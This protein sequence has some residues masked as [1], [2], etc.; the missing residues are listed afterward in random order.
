MEKDIYVNDLMHRFPG[1]SFTETP[2]GDLVTVAFLNGA[3]AEVA[4]ATTL[5]LVAAYDHIRFN[6]LGSR[7]PIFIST[8]VERDA[9]DVNFL[10]S[11]VLL[12][13][14]DDKVVDFLN[15]AGNWLSTGGVIGVKAYGGMVEDSV[16]G[17]TI[18]NA[19]NYKG[20][21]SASA[22]V[23]NSSGLIAFL[24]NGTA[25][26]LVVGAGGAGDYEVSFDASFTNSGSKNTTGTI[27]VNG[28]P[29]D[30]IMAEVEG[31]S[32]KLRIVTKSGLITL[33]DDDY[34][35]LRFKSE[36]NDDITIYQTEVSLNRIS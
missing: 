35:D 24:N 6:V 33:E 14:T 17:S 25:D 13:N 2:K 26:R 9:L 3:L 31:D 7:N 12:W 16:L 27:H 30:D 8:A 22:G 10:A 36:D 32:S 34:L 20:W 19:A 5:D 4:A 29:A 18:N 23:L 15:M 1:Y 21:K 11:G 28:S